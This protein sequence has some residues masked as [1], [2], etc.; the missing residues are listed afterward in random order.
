VVFLFQLF[1]T[2]LGFCER[3][4][5]FT[6]GLFEI[7]DAFLEANGNARRWRLAGFARFP[8]L[9]LRRFEERGHF[10][11]LPPGS[12]ARIDYECV[13]VDVAESDEF[14]NRADCGG[15]VVVLA[16]HLDQPIHPE[17]RKHRR[18]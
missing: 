5:F 4:A 18:F 2:L 17:L 14:L 8:L 12:I 11:D 1:V 9:R 6:Q 16:G 10:A 13:R 15:S 7:T 3:A